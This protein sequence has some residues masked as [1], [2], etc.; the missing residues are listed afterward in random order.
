MQKSWKQSTTI[1]QAA[2]EPVDTL[3]LRYYAATVSRPN[4]CERRRVKVAVDVDVVVVGGKLKAPIALGCG[5][6]G[7]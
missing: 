3:L 4:V 6:F 1:Q 2:S 7:L 5:S